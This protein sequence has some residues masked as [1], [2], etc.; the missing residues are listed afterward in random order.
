M[1]APSTLG[2]CHPRSLLK[3]DE[4]REKIPT[5]MDP[6]TDKSTVKLPKGNR[7][8]VQNLSVGKPGLEYA[9][10]M[11]G[12]HSWVEREGEPLVPIMAPEANERIPDRRGMEERGLREG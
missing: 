3:R 11:L 12:S 10:W 4:S 8:T 1:A 5:S 2:W 7:L 9:V 6:S